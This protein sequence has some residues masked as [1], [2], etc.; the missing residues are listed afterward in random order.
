MTD[1]IIY[2]K[3]YEAA[4]LID[5]N[6]YNKKE[7]LQSFLRSDYNK[8]LSHNVVGKLCDNSHHLAKIF[9]HN[10]SKNS[11][12]RIY[13][14]GMFPAIITVYAMLAKKYSKSLQDIEKE[15]N[16]DS[17]QKYGKEVQVGSYTKLFNTL[18]AEN[19]EV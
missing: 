10:C 19:S 12:N 14:S 9:M 7:A 6:D 16:F 18:I 17:L 8:W 2:R 11:N 4:K 5:I 13:I 1:D 15:F 3:L